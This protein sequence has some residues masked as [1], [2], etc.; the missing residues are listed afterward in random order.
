M[1]SNFKAMVGCRRH[2]G[3]VDSGCEI[4]GKSED[5]SLKKTVPLEGDVKKKV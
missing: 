3:L 5:Y 1:G 4:P 2:D